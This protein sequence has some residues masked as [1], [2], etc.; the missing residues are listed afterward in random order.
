[1]TVVGIIIGAI[2]V[3]FVLFLIFN[4][5]FLQQ[6]LIKF[7]GRTDE[8]MR[9]DASTPEG[10]R[11]YYNTVIREKEDLYNRASATYADVSGKLDATKKDVYQANKDIMKIKQQLNMC[12]DDN[13][14]ND[15]MLY[16]NKL[17]TLESKIEVLKD[18]ITELEE[19]QKHQKEVRD[20]AAVELQKL[21]EEKERVVFQLEADHQTIA[22]HQSLDTFATNNESERMLERVREGAKKTRERAQGSRIAYDTSAQA[23]ENRM[24][25]AEQ[26]RNAQSVIDELKRQRGNK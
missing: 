24:R 16:A 2:I 7:R 26:N 4:K 23:A 9:Q 12:V 17:V 15:A 13:N 18:V 14:D 5:P 8:I 19:A 25:Q 22:L 1:M 3:V 11:D 6:L 20:Q 10:A 21:R